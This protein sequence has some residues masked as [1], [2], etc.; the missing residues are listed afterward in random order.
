MQGIGQCE[1]V[2]AIN[3]DEGCDMVKRADLSA[4]GDSTEILTRLVNWLNKENK[5]LTGERQMS[6][7]N[8]SVISLVS[9]GEH[10]TSRRPR[11][12]E[13]DARAIELGIKLVGENFKPCTRV[14][15]LM[16]LANKQH[17]EAI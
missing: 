2:I 14:S 1:K 5:P 8:L 15:C 9:I 6:H 13:Q 3:T 16:M 7:D 11:R 10:P 4:I 12:A 17:C